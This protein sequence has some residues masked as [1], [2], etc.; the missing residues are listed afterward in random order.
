MKYGTSIAPVTFFDTK[1][2]FFTKQGFANYMARALQSVGM[3][4]LNAINYYDLADPANAERDPGGHENA[5]F[6]FDYPTN[7]Y[8][9]V[10]GSQYRPCLGLVNDIYRGWT[11]NDAGVAGKTIGY[12]VGSN[13]GFKHFRRRADRI[14]R[15]DM[16]SA[17]NLSFNSRSGFYGFGAYNEDYGYWYG[18]TGAIVG[19]SRWKLFSSWADANM[20]ELLFVN[21]V[22]VHLSPAGLVVQVGSHPSRRDE[23]CNIL[24]FMVAFHGGRIPNRERPVIDD[25]LR[26]MNDPVAWFDLGAYA[27]DVYANQTRSDMYTGLLGSAKIYNGVKSSING[28]TMAYLRS[29]DY[30]DE[31]VYN[32]AQSDVYPRP[33][34]TVLNGNGVHLLH[35]I[36]LNP[37]YQYDGN[38][39][40]SGN[41]AGVIDSVKAPNLVGLTKWADVYFLHG[42]ALSDRVVAPGLKTDP[43][44][45]KEWYM[46]WSTP[47]G[48]AFGIDYT[49]VS[50]ISDLS[51]GAENFTL[52]E[53]ISLDVTAVAATTP[54]YTRS[55]N[56][57]DETFKVGTPR[58]L[59]GTFSSLLG[60]IN[61]YVS[62]FEFGEIDVAVNKRWNKPA[63]VNMFSLPAYGWTGTYN[64]TK[65]MQ[66]NLEL[67]NLS[68]DIRDV[69]YVEY[70]Y[71]GRTTSSP[72]A[73]P[74][75][76]DY[77]F[78]YVY[79]GGGWS[80]EVAGG[81][82]MSSFMRVGSNSYQNFYYN[83]KL[84]GPKGTHYL[85]AAPDKRTDVQRFQPNANGKAT[86]MFS[87]A[88]NYG[89]PQAAYQLSVDIQNIVIKRYRRS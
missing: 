43:T 35:R 79:M 21:R 1:P 66:L 65:Y 45:N 51:A 47:R 60:N 8:F 38:R 56:R 17:E 41:Y 12:Y 49:G 2:Q 34:P 78:Q 85:P 10:N 46:I 13:V 64:T 71:R 58:T 74:E 62:Q 69:Y 53:S 36:A 25:V 84:Y 14:S 76:Y 44:T 31:A 57:S 40:N 28:A 26:D 11:N 55:T 86:I 4:P 23:T 27:N 75:N 63:G 89:D 15:S 32:N 29:I 59:M 72:A 22:F 20:Q 5:A 82:M 52:M 33:S 37:Y 19:W 6:W 87:A 39:N 50:T 42:I 9:L 3:I 88:H 16:Y 70:E 48:Q 83:F 67:D 81:M 24:N 73:P 30:I 7:E 80:T 68:T 18:Q 54:P 61:M 77:H